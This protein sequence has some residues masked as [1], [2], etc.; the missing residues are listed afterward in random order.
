[1]PHAYIRLRV[2]P[3]GRYQVRWVDRDQRSRRLHFATPQRARAFT[4]GLAGSRPALLPRQHRGP[5]VQRPGHA[6]VA[7]R[8]RPARPLL[9]GRPVGASAVARRLGVRQ[10]AVRPEPVG[11][12]VSPVVAVVAAGAWS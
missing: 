4:A 1:M 10:W 6:L 12:L 8:H 9:S 2:L 5:G 3:G 11:S 7:T